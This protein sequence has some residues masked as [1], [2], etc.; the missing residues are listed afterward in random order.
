M[1]DESRVPLYVQIRNDMEAAKNLREL[2]QASQAISKVLN[3]AHQRQLS[4]IYKT[5]KQTLKP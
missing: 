3:M 5:K 4:H 1:N 2:D